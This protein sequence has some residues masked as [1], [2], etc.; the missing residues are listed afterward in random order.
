M[1]T[2][3]ATTA[4]ANFASILSAVHARHES[5]EIVQQGVSCAFLIPVAACA[6][7]THELADDLADAELSATD[8]RAFA[9]TLRTGRKTLQPLKNPWG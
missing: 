2:V 7:S 3:E 1:K 9:A 5:F 6:S 8:R 4:A